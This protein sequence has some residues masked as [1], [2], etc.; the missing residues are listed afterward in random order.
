MALIDNILAY[1]KLDE[2]SGTTITDSTG[3]YNGA[4]GSATINQTGAATNTNKSYYFNNLNSTTKATLPS[5]TAFDF[6]TN[7]FSIAFWI[8][9]NWSSA[10]GTA[11]LGSTA[12]FGTNSTSVKWD[13]SGGGFGEKL[14]FSQYNGSTT[15]S[16]GSNTLSADT[17]YHFVI[18]RNGDTLSIYKNGSLE[19][20]STGW[21]ARNCNFTKATGQ[22]TLG[23]W[24]ADATDYI[25]VYADELG[26]WTRALSSTEAAS[27][28]NSGN[29]IS[30]P[31]A[32]GPTNLK[33]YNTNLKANIKSINGNL[34][35]NVKS[36]NTN[37]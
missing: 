29:G 15:L 34:I 13:W 1:Y 24:A 11:F 36:L 7:N 21:S 28:Y 35:A 2:T 4:T 18:S 10:N 17:W 19:N 30:Y 5:S 8:K 3:S 12:S 23:W 22:P 26:F 9:G 6:G 37:S 25:Q 20:S 14:A 31:F 16:L 33:S 32:A 27:L